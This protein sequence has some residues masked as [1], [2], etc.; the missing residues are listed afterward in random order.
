MKRAFVEQNIWQKKDSELSVEESYHLLT[1]LRAKPEEMIEIFDGQ[2]QTARAKLIPA[3]KNI[4]GIKIMGES[5]RRVEPYRPP[6]ILLQAMPKHS[7]M[8][9]IIQ[10]ATELGVQTIVPVI[11]ERVIVKLN[12]RSADKRRARWRKIVLASAKQSHAAWLPEISP[13]VSL[14]EA[15]KAVQSDLRL[16]G[17]LAPR[18]PLF[19]EV[20][21]KVSR[22]AVKSIALVIGPEGDLTDG[23]RELL[24]AARFEPVSFGSGVLRVETAAV[25]GLSV[26]NYEFPRKM[27]NAECRMKNF[28]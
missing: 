9:V 25:F 10:K 14:A 19:K 11:T 5:I 1:V 12:K 8:D 4:A 2:G 17:S 23:E 16:F 7:G 27:R 21:A 13:I 28:L 24:S 3:R 18:T 20:L 22:P 15:V 26:L 6:F